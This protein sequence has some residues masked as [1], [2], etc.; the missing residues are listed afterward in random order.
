M[1]STVLTVL[2]TV[3]VGA[4]VMLMVL[5]TPAPIRYLGLPDG[6]TCGYSG[7]SIKTCVA[8]GRAYLC[9]ID[10]D[11]RIAQCAPVAVVTPE[12]RP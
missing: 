12:R 2:A 3:V 11:D 4:F 8:D 10:W 7:D 9:A 1:I 6:A 5:W